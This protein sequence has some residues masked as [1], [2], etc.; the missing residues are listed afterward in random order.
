MSSIC[1]W[2]IC[3]FVYINLQETNMDRLASVIRC[4][5][6]WYKFHKCLQGNSRNVWILCRKMWIKCRGY[7]NVPNMRLNYIYYINDLIFFWNIWSLYILGDVALT[8]VKGPLEALL[9][10]AFG[11]VVGVFLWYFPS[12]NGV[13]HWETGCSIDKLLYDPWHSN[14]KMNNSL[15]H[16]HVKKYCKCGFFTGWNIRDLH[17]TSNSCCGYFRRKWRTYELFY[18]LCIQSTNTSFQNFSLDDKF[19]VIKSL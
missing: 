13:S 11:C 2:F 1:I 8:I 14:L 4:F 10:V 5:V 6:Y 19:Y 16:Y 7:S 15:R 3:I 18:S 9:G 12:K 17:L